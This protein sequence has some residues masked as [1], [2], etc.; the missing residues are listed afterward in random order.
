MNVDTEAGRRFQR[1]ID[2][3]K[4]NPVDAERIAALRANPTSEVKTVAAKK[5]KSST[6]KKNP[7]KRKTRRKKRKTSRRKKTSSRRKTTRRKSSRKKRKTSRKRRRNPATPARASSSSKSRSTSSRSATR[8]TRSTSRT[9]PS[10]TNVNV[11]VAP[12]GGGSRRANPTKRRSTKKRSNPTKRRK[13]AS[14]RRSNPTRRKTAPRRPSSAIA[15]PN[16]APQG[17]LGGLIGNPAGP[18]SRASLTGFAIAAGGVGLGLVASNLL[19][20]FV[21]TRTPKD[22]KNPWY[23]SAA[24]AAQ[25]RRPDAMRLAAQGGLAL[26]SMALTYWTRSGRILPWLFAGTAVGAGAGMVQ[27]LVDWWVM[28]WLF[29][30]D[31]PGEETLS[32]RLYPLEQSAVQDEVDKIFEN[33]GTAVLSGGQAETP[34][35]SGVLAADAVYQLGEPPQGKARSSAGQEPQP[36]SISGQPGQPNFI[37]TGR[38]G[39]CDSCGGRGGCWSTCSNLDEECLPCRGMSESGGMVYEGQ[40]CKHT[41]GPNESLQQIA[42]A[43]G[44]DMNVLNAMNVGSPEDYWQPGNQVT[45]PFH[46]CKYLE[47]MGPAVPAASPV[48]TA[49]SVNLGEAGPVRSLANLFPDDDAEDEDD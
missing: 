2:E 24:A 32:N 38:L 6:R 44:V 34:M 33:L 17:A 5:T 13:T 3:Y 31:D 36:K 1:D 21:A 20:R 40:R 35:I 49:S 12:A 47:Q 30:V 45:C 9:T 28:S 41:V 14:K 48:T 10:H 25:A 11:R 4:L 7:R 29:K 39:E 8:S 18:F 42:G 37:R 22:G 27:K 15:Q 26:G 23:G 46:L 16:P 19:D 43:A